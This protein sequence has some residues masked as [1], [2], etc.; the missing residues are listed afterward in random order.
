V[1]P[2]AKNTAELADEILDGQKVRL[3]LQF[4]DRLKLVLDQS[5]AFFRRTR[6]PT[7][8]NALIGQLSKP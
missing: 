4:A 3:V 1:T 7:I 8:C 5:Q 2:S 6:R